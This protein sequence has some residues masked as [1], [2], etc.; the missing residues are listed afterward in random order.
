[1]FKK[2]SIIFLVLES[3]SLLLNTLFTSYSIFRPLQEFNSFLGMCKFP[4]SINLVQS[5]LSKRIF[6]GATTQFVYLSSLVNPVGI[7]DNKSTSQNFIILEVIVSLHLVISGSIIAE[8]FCED[9]L[10]IFLVATSATVYD[11]DSA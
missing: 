11:S 4:Q 6:N 1:M 3:L 8:A 5:F 10:I 9:F 2:V 7:I